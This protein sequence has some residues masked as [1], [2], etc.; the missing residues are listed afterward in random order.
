MSQLS[1]ISFPCKSCC[2]PI[3]DIHNVVVITPKPLQASST[4]T[5]TGCCCVRVP[6][7]R[8]KVCQYKNLASAQGLTHCGC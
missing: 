8:N 5:N 1:S 7:I 2:S 3:P 6:L 4:S